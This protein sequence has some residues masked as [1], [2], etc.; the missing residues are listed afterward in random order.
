MVFRNKIFPYPIYHSEGDKNCYTST[1]FETNLRKLDKENNDILNFVV[2]LKVFEQT[3]LE[4]LEKKFITFFIHIECVE[5]NFFKVVESSNTEIEILL[6]T[7]DIHKK[8][9]IH[10]FLIAKEDIDSFTS[11]NFIDIFAGN[12]FFIERGNIVGIGDSFLINVEK[13]FSNSPKTFSLF[14]INYH[15]LE[16]NS[17]NYDIS[18]EEDK[19]HINLPKKHYDLYLSVL[20]NPEIRANLNA[21]FILPVLISLVERI[22]FEEAIDRNTPWVGA[23]ISAYKNASKNQ[24]DL[25]NKDSINSIEVA[26]KIY[27]DCITKGF[28]QLINF[29]N[30]E[31]LE[32]DN[33]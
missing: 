24:L 33:E 7:K 6:E 21:L 10:T 12:D 19:I 14:E 29:D 31:K 26:Q 16:N 22:K 4:L 25:D 17:I 13:E 8:I 5:T 18:P 30:S 32:F 2:N 9:Q 28:E 23:I 1:P 20:E 11:N 15:L 3:L 27:D